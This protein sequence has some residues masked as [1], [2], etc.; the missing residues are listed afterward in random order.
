MTDSSVSYASGSLIFEWKTHETNTRENQMCSKSIAYK[1]FFNLPG[2][3]LLLYTKK[4]LFW[5]IDLVI[6]LEN[7]EIW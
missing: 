5:E 7:V 2:I 4:D 3:V 1:L 6:L